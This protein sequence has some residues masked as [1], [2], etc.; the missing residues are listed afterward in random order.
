MY[1]LNW[2]PPQR[3]HQFLHIFPP[4]ISLQHHFPPNIITSPPLLL[5]AHY[6][7]FL[8]KNTGALALQ[9]KLE[10]HCVDVERTSLPW[11][12]LCSPV[13]LHLWLSP[14]PWVPPLRTEW[15]LFLVM[16]LGPCTHCLLPFTPASPCVW[17]TNYSA[18]ARRSLPLLWDRKTALAPH[19]ALYTLSWWLLSYCFAIA[20][21]QICL[22]T[23]I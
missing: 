12:I 22:S 5:L 19:P 21:V 16:V 3:L 23:R 18:P 15:S 6:S 4:N 1:F 10:N 2:Q 14:L 8:I 13:L 9:K 20:W 7:S 17:L 11:Q